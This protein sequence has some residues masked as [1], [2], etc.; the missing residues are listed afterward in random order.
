LRD[1]GAI[2]EEERVSSD[3]SILEIN[4]ERKK[5]TVVGRAWWYKYPLKAQR[6]FMGGTAALAKTERIRRFW[7][8][9]LMGMRMLFKDFEHLVAQLTNSPRVPLNSMAFPNS[10]SKY[11]EI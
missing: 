11:K 3:L 8:T 10:N 7:M 2:M 4:R 5:M 6:S 9:V 1:G